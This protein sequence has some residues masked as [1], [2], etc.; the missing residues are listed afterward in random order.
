MNDRKIVELQLDRKIKNFM[1][2]EVYC[3]FG[4]PAVIKVNPFINNI[5]APTIYWLSCPYLNYEVDRLEAESDLISELGERLKSDQ[6]FKKMMEAAHQKYAASRKNI[7]SSEQ[8]QQAKN[9]SED[10]YITL[11]ESGVGGIRDKEGIKCLHTHLADFLVE[12]SNP[13]GK[14]VFK[15]IDWPESCKICKERVDQFESSCN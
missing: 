10:L 5:P 11:I 8:L 1:E 14:I 4:Y 2:T 13:V 6:E 9:I 12:Q 15:K 3:P 7:L